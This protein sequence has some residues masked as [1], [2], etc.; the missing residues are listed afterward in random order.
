MVKN[1]GILVFMNQASV[2][3]SQYNTRSSNKIYKNK[4]YD[5]KQEGKKKHRSHRAD[6]IRCHIFQYFNTA[7]TSED[8]ITTSNERVVI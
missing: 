4:K 1:T 8:N 3:G 6:L 5:E 7:K 2:V